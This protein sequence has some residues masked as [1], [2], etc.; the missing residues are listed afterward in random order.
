M[1][2]FKVI[3]FI[4][5]SQIKNLM[6]Y[7]LLLFFCSTLLIY[8]TTHLTYYNIFTH[9]LI[10][11]CLFI[12]AQHYS[13][14]CCC[15]CQ[16]FSLDFNCYLQK[17]TILFSLTLSLFISSIELLLCLPVNCITDNL[18]MFFM[19]CR[20]QIKKGEIKEKKINTKTTMITIEYKQ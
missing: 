7:Y 2:F 9:T 17:A 13:C 6:F 4:M 12:N 5:L 10:S 18:C 19:C 8:T 14:C 15:C 1:F 3:S 16:Y 20:R 11:L